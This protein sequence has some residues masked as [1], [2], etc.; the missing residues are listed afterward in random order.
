MQPLIR[1]TVDFDLVVEVALNERDNA[2]CFEP[3]VGVRTLDC[4]EVPELA[5]LGCLLLQLCHLYGKTLVLRFKAFVLSANIAVRADVRDQV[6]DRR[7]D[8][9]DASSTGLAA[10]CVMSRSPYDASVRENNVIAIPSTTIV[11]NQLNGRVSDIDSR[12]AWEGAQWVDQAGWRP[13]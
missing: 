11:M 10:D 3:L 2:C 5:V 4:G 6:S 1:S 13:P 9:V 12:P 8:A 7:E